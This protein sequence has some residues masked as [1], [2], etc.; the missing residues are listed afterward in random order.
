MPRPFVRP[1]GP[2]VA[3]FLL[4]LFIPVKSTG[5]VAVVFSFQGRLKQHDQPVPRLTVVRGRGQNRVPWAP[6][7]AAG[8][9]EDLSGE[10]LGDDR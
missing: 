5:A 2:E 8:K 10:D 9:A 3:I 7:P 4:P 1:Q 6:S